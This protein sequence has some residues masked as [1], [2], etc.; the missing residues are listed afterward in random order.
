MEAGGGD[1]SR[2]R[3][4]LTCP[5]QYRSAKAAYLVAVRVCTATFRA[6][7]APCDYAGERLQP[8]WRRSR[9]GGNWRWHRWPNTRREQRQKIIGCLRTML[10]FRFHRF[11]YSGAHCGIDCRVQSLRWRQRFAQC[12]LRGGKRRL[13]G[14][15]KI[16]SRAQC[17]N[18]GGN[19]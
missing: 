5:W 1:R 14:Q 19:S 10:D 17:V 12:P 13:A 6:V 3:Q 7:T 4:Y 11:H 2:G 8:I 15:K 18:I 16:E 9:C